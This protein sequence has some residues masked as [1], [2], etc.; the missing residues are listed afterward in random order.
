MAPLAA[1]LE[2]CRI[3]TAPAW[4]GAE[5]QAGAADLGFQQARARSD[6][7]PPGLAYPYEDA[8]FAFNNLHHIDERGA[9]YGRSSAATRQV[10]VLDR[11]GR[12]AAVIAD[13]DNAKSQCFRLTYLNEQFPAPPFAP[14]YLYLPTD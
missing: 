9:C 7:Q 5:A 10:L 2:R 6:A 8:W 14:Y 3:T 11:S 13:I 4:A 1:Q 12:V